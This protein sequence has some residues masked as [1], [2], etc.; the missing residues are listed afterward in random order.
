MNFLYPRHNIDRI[1][2]FYFRLY[3]FEN[4]K[5]E[6]KLFLKK[7]RFDLSEWKFYIYLNNNDAHTTIIVDSLWRDE[8]NNSYLQEG[9]YRWRIDAVSGELGGAP[10]TEG[11]ES[12]WT[13]FT[14]K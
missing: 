1:N 2:N 5:Y 11:S 14:V 10:E 9:D 4:T 13:Y 8:E 3:Y 12:P 6:L 7:F